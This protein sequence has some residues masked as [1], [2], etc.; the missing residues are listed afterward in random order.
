MPRV[1]YKQIADDLRVR[2]TGGQLSAGSDLPTEAELAETWQTSRG[3]VR[4]ALAALQSE[5]LITT[6]RG[7]PARVIGSAMNQSV[8]VSVPFSVWA[9][10]LG[11]RSGA[12]TQEVSRRRADAERAAALGVDEGDPVVD[13]VRLRLLDGRPCMVERRTYRDDIGRLLFNVDLD[14]E[15]ITRFLGSRGHTYAETEFV[16]DAVAAT[17]LDARLLGID[18]FAPLLRLRR[19]TWDDQ[20]SAFEVSDARYRSDIVRFTIPSSRSARH[21]DRTIAEP[22]AGGDEGGTVGSGSADESASPAAG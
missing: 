17:K 12:L 13:V 6:A 15:S 20:G 14:H 9:T 18:R 1:V 21:L 11:S 5:G 19:V 22:T 10:Q 16:I 7:R 8:D 4:N 3:P 2:I